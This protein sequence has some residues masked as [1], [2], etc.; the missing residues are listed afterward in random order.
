MQILIRSTWTNPHNSVSI[1]VI[2]SP[3]ELMNWISLHF[4][5]H[6]QSRS[7]KCHLN[8]LLCSFLYST[9]KS[10]ERQSQNTLCC[11]K[12]VA[13][14]LLVVGLY[15]SHLQLQTTFKNTKKPHGT[16]LPWILPRTLFAYEQE[17]INQLKII[18]YAFS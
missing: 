11:S 5:Y 15:E 8:F 2:E 18:N 17:H 9:S 3:S 10:P 16:L 14:D 13:R 1:C 12:L 4:L 7:L 6:E